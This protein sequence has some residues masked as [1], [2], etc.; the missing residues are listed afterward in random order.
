[1]GDTDD[2]YEYDG[3]SAECPSPMASFPVQAA[4][5]ERV[6]SVA[7]TALFSAMKAQLAAAC[8]LLGC[9]ED[10]SYR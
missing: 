10:E 4:R 8:E 7:V 6:T 1:M 9:S 2:S 3:S 5:P